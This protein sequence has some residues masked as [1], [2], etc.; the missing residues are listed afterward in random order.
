MATIRRRKNNWQ[1]I[2]RLKGYPA[3]YKTFSQ[4]HDAKIWALENELKLKREEAGIIK[5][6][7]P[8]FKDIALKYIKEAIAINDNTQF[9]ELSFQLN[10]ICNLAKKRLSI[11]YSNQIIKSEQDI[12]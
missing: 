2:I 5:I 7:Y 4:K 12:N 8:S 9:N 1:V 3:I 6:K 10:V 11:S